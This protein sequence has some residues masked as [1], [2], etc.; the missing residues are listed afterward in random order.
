MDRRILVA[1]VVAGALLTAGCSAEQPQQDPTRSNSPVARPTD[2]PTAPGDAPEQLDD[3]S[4]LQPSPS[5]PPLRVDAASR[6]EATK[7]AAA[8]MTLFARQDV[9]A[10]TWWSELVPLLSAKAAQ[11]YR[12]VDP[13]NVPVTEMTGSVKLLPQETASVARVSIPTNAGVYLVV[14]SRTAAEPRWVVE[15]FTP[16]ESAGD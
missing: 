16:P 1:T 7:A 11:D 2:L 12:Y 8:A 9:D 6:A 3:G 15:R 10:Q 13:A 14:L 5:S 4:T